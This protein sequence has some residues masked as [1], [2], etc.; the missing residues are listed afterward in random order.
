[1]AKKRKGRPPKPKSERKSKMVRLRISG[2]EYRK[3][4]AK[5]RAAGLTVSEFL[6]RQ[7]GE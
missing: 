7:A 5:A 4:A 3:I 1:M 2:A 6:R